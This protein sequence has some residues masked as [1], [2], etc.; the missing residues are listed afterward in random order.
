MP[1]YKYNILKRESS[2]AYLLSIILDAYYPNYTS[3]PHK[4]LLISLA[5]LAL[6]KVGHLSAFP[7]EWWILR[8]LHY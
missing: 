3:S 7:L 6:W 5:F 4:K 2:V 8:W 1:P